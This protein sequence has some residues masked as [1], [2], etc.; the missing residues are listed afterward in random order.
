MLRDK[1]TTARLGSRRLSALRV[2]KASALASDSTNSHREHSATLDR[3]AIALSGLCLVHCLAIPVALI[4]GPLFG[5]WLTDTENQIHWLLLA[6]AAPIS[7]I[8]L[9][10]AKSRPG[11]KRNWYAGVLGLLLMLF[12]AAHLFGEQFEVMLTTVGVLG[13][14]YA[15]VRNLIAQHHTKKADHAHHH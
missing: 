3:F 1:V 9:W 11:G 6:M 15:H 7:L 13:L 5:G 10:R 8:A 12:G 14:I 2:D 4:F